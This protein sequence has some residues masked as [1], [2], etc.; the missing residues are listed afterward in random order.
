MSSLLMSGGGF[1]MSLNKRVLV[2]NLT[3]EIAI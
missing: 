3:Y 1:K 2:P